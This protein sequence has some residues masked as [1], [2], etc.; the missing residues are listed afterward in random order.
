MYGIIEGQWPSNESKYDSLYLRSYIFLYLLHLQ[1]L[2]Y[3]LYPIYLSTKV[4]VSLSHSLSLYSSVSLDIARK[5]VLSKNDFN[6]RNKREEI[7]KV[8]RDQL[9]LEH[10]L[11]QSELSIF[12]EEFERLVHSY[13]PNFMLQCQLINTH[14]QTP[15]SYFI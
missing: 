14:F 13:V 11:D 12:R 6:H 3:L 15:V 5:Y 9:F 10:P 2:L 8:L 7:V 1:Y 4:Y